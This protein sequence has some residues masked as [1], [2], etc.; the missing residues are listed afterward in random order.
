[1]GVLQNLEQH[2]RVKRSKKTERDSIMP[3]KIEN[4][5]LLPSTYIVLGDHSSY[6]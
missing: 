2:K 6:F 4:H 3:Q 1:M 5:A